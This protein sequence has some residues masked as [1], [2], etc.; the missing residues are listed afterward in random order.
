MIEASKRRAPTTMLKLFFAWGRDKRKLFKT[1]MHL[2]LKS[3]KR[4]LL[5]RLV[6]QNLSFF[7]L[8]SKE[9]FYQ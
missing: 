9:K 1:F 6:D 3:R 4:E 2:A 7:F 8:S 5:S